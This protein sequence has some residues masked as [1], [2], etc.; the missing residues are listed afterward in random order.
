MK[1]LITNDDGI[2]APGL[3]TLCNYLHQYHEVFVVAPDNER[4]GVSQSIT[5][6]RPVFHKE[7][8][9]GS[10]IHGI[11][12]NGYPVDC[13]K[14]A[15]FELCPFR[16]PPARCALPTPAEPN[17]APLCRLAVDAV[18]AAIKDYQQKRRELGGEAATA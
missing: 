6:R 13:V 8:R 7:Y 1:I 11:G 4:S 16:P 17:R 3:V 2:T 10:G 12:V 15:M 18:K 14:V 5:Y 9:I